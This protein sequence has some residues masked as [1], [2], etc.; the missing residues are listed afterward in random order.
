MSNFDI[1]IRGATVVTAEKIERDDVGISGEKIAAIQTEI[2]N[3]AVTEINAEGL[4]IFPGVID[5]HVHFN[6]PGR[7]DWEGIATGSNAVA[8]GGGTMFFDMPLNA[9]P[10]TLDAASFE[11]KRA[12]AEK[13]SRVDFAFWGGLTP[14]NLGTMGELANCGVIGF[15]AF[16][17]NSGIDDFLSVDSRTLREGMKR[18]ASLRLPV[19]VHAESDAMTA[20][21]TQNAVAA[22]KTSAR[23]FLN[24]RPIAAELEA[25]RNAIELAGETGCSL[26]IVH[27]SCADGVRIV[28]EAAARG[29]DVTCETCPHYLI[30]TD[31]DMERLGP[32]AKCAPPLR[33]ALEQESLWGELMADKIHTVGSDHSPSPPEMKRGANFFQAWG[34][35]SGAQHLLPLLLTRDIDASL[36]AR[37]TSAKVARRFRLPASKGTL[38]AGGDADLCL[39]DLGADYEMTRDE[40]QYRHRQSPYIGKRLSARVKQTFLHGRMIYG[41]N[42]FFG[43]PA[44][45][46]VKPS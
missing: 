29:Q 10:P 14:A 40:L 13:S 24:C 11:L 20:R 32:V 9:H 18:A 31:K 12:A 4:H 7:T 28:A 43:T 30:L 34:G 23:D 37:V 21:L 16:M 6:E 25:I 33:S 41:D 45:R 22:G 39:V 1:I 38:A 27:V 3:N 26:H 35:I 19:A 42:K 36:A 46:L 8:A 15:K 44:G 17:C 2:S 5:A